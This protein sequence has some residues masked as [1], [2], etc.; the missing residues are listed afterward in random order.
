MHDGDAVPVPEPK[1]TLSEAIETLNAKFCRHIGHDLHILNGAF[2]PAGVV[3]NRCGKEW[4]CV[5][6]A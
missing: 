1:Y 5:A 3:C 2:D 6:N 4:K